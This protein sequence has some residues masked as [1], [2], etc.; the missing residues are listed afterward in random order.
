MSVFIVAVS[1]GVDSVVLLDM[2]TKGNHAQYGL[3]GEGQFLEFTSKNLAEG[4]TPSHELVVAHFD[5]GIRPESADDAAFVKSLAE[6][7]GLAYETVREE[8]GPGASEEL[9]RDRR[10]AFLRQVAKRHSGTIMT[11]H[12]K[13][14]L[15]ESIAIN[16]LRGTGW[17]GLAVLNSPD[18]ERP[19]LDMTKKE[20]IEYAKENLLEWREDS[21]NS[22]TSYLRNDVRQKLT[23]LDDQ[24]KELLRL[25][26]NRQVALS[27][28][29]DNESNPLIQTSPY[30]RHLFINTPHAAA[31]E[32]LR[33]VLIREIGQGLPRPQLERVLL[34]IK[35]QKPGKVFDI[36][37]NHVL[38]FTRTDFVV[39]KR[40]EVVS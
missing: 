29:V 37:A 5:H 4:L 18:I 38:Q 36:D 8:L 6:K 3:Q 23:Y 26:R 35:T 13:D 21:T 9:A 31:L 7:Y 32:L 16:L 11:A 15:V 27:K 24:T 19:L 12:H 17:R 10:Y 39:S 1:G 22:D 33:A 14:D 40:S 20:I 34:A 25:Y 2:L 28:L 30:K